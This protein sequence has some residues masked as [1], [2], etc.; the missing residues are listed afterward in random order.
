VQQACLWMVRVR[1]V[2]VRVY[3][4]GQGCNGWLSC[5]QLGGVEATFTST[6]TFSVP[7]S[8]LV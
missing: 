7:V 3:V 8:A 6:A 1:R 4:H 2:C 5:A